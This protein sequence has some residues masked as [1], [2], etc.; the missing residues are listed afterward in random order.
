MTN[1]RRD[2]A[3]ATYEAVRAVERLHAPL[4]DQIGASVRNHAV[5]TPDGP[6]ITQ[7]ARRAILRD[8]DGMLDGIYGKR[9]GAASQLQAV[10]EQHASQAAFLPVRDAVATIRRH[11][12]EGLRLR[13]G[14][15]PGE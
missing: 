13:M 15:K 14:D 11:V 7:E 4:V 2:L 6:R 10:I 8:V 1:P 9:R 3:K 12:P 5:D